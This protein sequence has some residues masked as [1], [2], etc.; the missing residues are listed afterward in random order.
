MIDAATK[1]LDFLEANWT[2]QEVTFSKMF[3]GYREN[4]A[5]PQSKPQLLIDRPIGTRQ[6]KSYL[7]KG[8]YRVEDT[9]ILTLFLT[10]HSYRQTN[11]DV[12]EESFRQ[13]QTEVDRILACNRQEIAEINF[14]DL[15]GWRDLTDRDI[16]PVTFEA[17][18]G[19]KIVYFLSSC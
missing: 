5:S 18:Q 1:I 2:V 16:E 6:V 9:L 12:V 8:I 17:N 7:T 11:I 13:I 3:H 14:V 15:M 19:L 10:P 4:P